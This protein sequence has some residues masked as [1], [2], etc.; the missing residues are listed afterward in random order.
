M[1]IS[2]PYRNHDFFL[3]TNLLNLFVSTT[4]AATTFSYAYVYQ[5]FRTRETFWAP[6][7]VNFHSAWHILF[8]FGTFLNVQ[9]L[10]PLV[11]VGSML[12]PWGLQYCV[13][14]CHRKLATFQLRKPYQRFYL[15]S[16]YILHGMPP[17]WLTPPKPGDTPFV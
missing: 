16:T 11:T 2:H 10:Y 9:K 13:V 15:P 5:S 8:E 17:F 7:F 3:T 4:D 14:A 6:N 12:K 1:L